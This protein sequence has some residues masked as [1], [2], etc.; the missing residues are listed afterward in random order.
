M[1]IYS[2]NFFCSV[3]ADRNDAS[4]L[5]VRFRSKFH[6]DEF[7]KVFTGYKVHKDEYADYLYRA[8]VPKV[9]FA[10]IMSDL[11]R[12]IDYY[13]F[14]NSVADRGCTTREHT[15]L[16]NVWSDLRDYQEIIKRLPN[17]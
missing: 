12:D 5:V 14:K 4:M 10:E 15:A 7:G 3:V 11:M 1:W 2:K 9:L 17:G 6:A 8:F 13:N 16:M